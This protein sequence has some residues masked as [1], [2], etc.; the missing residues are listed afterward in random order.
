[1]KRT[2]RTTSWVLVALVAL[3][4]VLAPLPAAAKKPD[5]V[6]NGGGQAI[7]TDLSDPDLT[8][9]PIQYAIAG[10]VAGDGSARGHINFNFHGEFARVWGAEPD[11]TD[12]FRIEGQVDSGRVEPDGTI[13]LEGWV[14]E[15]DFRHGDGVILRIDDPFVIEV[16][17]R[18]GP[19]SFLLQWC[20]LPEW[21]V[22]VP[23]GTL[24][25]H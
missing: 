15:T 12:M 2:I 19:D 23:G 9:Y 8:Q 22:E 3:T 1:M 18:H 14:T 17:G 5:V 16:G 6:V 24:H 25:I 21:L 20:L 13:V 11:A 10:V 4:F 7:L